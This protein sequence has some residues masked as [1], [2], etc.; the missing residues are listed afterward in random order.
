MWLGV[1][2][3]SK[4]GRGCSAK[5]GSYSQLNIPRTASRT[6]IEQS[7]C[8]CIDKM[9]ASYGLLLLLLTL[10]CLQWAVLAQQW[11]GYVNEEGGSLNYGCPQDTA[12]LSGV[13][14]DYF[15]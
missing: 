14:S 4:E 7:Y 10:G 11:S 5:I 12:A 13:A 15:V 2:V 3:P 9:A 1:K 6:A 8:A